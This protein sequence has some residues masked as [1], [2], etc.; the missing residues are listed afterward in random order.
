LFEWNEALTRAFVSSYRCMPAAYRKNP[1]PIVLFNILFYFRKTLD[2]KQ[3]NMIKYDMKKI[4][5]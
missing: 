5:F 1:V 2:S 4:R 3:I